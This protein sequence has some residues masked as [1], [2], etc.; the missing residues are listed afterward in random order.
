MTSTVRFASGPSYTGIRREARAS[1]DGFRPRRARRLALA[2][3]FLFGAAMIALAS[4]AWGRRVALAGVLAALFATATACRTETPD[5]SAPKAAR[6][7][8][9]RPAKTRETAPAAERPESPDWEAA[10]DHEVGYDP[11]R[12]AVVVRV[13][14]AEGFHVYT[15]GETIG[16]PLRVA[17]DEDGAFAIDGEVDYPKGVTKDLPIGRSVI[18]EGEAEVVAPI[19]AREA[20][21]EDAETDAPSTAHGTF[22]YQVCTDRACDRPRTEP[23]AVRVRPTT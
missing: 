11:A 6:V 2:R 16:K 5:P 10:F 14:V 1:S 22:R 13:E 7:G 17:L 4:A 21:A 19:R 15:N 12:S 3:I 18:V 20:S 8:E 9:N 23:F